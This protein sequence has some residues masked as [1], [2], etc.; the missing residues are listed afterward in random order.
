VTRGRS[1]T[2]ETAQPLR[3]DAR[4]NHDRILAAARAAFAERG[5]DVRMLGVAELAGVGVG[6]VYRHF[7]SK[8]DLVIALARELLQGCIDTASGALERHD[9]GEAVAWLVYENARSMADHRGLHDALAG[10]TFAFGH[11]W[12]DNEL[13]ARSV[14]VIERAQKAKALRSDLTIDDWQALM[15][16]LSAAIVFGA[17]PERQAALVL[18]ALRV[19]LHGSG[20]EDVAC[21]E[22]EHEKR[23][24][25]AR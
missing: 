10:L 18:A 16:G 3:A 24:C 25:R 14:S 5:Q 2:T 1:S 23:R 6:T 13:C 8:D 17:D 15:C 21:A 11:P 12:Q 9:A 20:L 4:R 22:A 19:K 7:A